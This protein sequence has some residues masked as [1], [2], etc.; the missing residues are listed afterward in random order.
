ML[1]NN[2]IY[3]PLIKTWALTVSGAIGFARGS[4]PTSS[5][6]PKPQF[7]KT[8]IRLGVPHNDWVDHTLE[9]IVSK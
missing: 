2:R 5:I 7:F 1:V 9:E 4:S 6:T 8:I 3:L